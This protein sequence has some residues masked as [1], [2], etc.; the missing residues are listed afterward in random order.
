MS[1]RIRREVEPPRLAF[2]LLETTNASASAGN[3]VAVAATLGRLAIIGSTT[4]RNVAASALRSIPATTPHHP[5][6]YV[7]CRL[8]ATLT[9]VIGIVFLVGP[10]CPPVQSREEPVSRLTSS[11]DVALIAVVTVPR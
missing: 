3:V 11:E 7:E 10:V 8:P 4:T 2:G 9:C 1:F 6:T 5:S